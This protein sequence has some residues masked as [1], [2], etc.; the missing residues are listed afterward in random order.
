M[1]PLTSVAE[2][3]T[4]FAYTNYLG[5]LF[6]IFSEDSLMENSKGIISHQKFLVFLLILAA[7]G[8]FALVEYLT[9]GLLLDLISGV[10]FSHQYDSF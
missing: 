10:L 3:A 8:M 4:M 5:Y 1:K 9:G 7:C 6:Y 2:E